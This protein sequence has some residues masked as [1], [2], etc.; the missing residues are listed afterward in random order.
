[1]EMVWLETCAAM[2]LQSP[3][4]SSLGL[5]VTAELLFPFAAHLGSA[6]LWGGTDALCRLN[7]LQKVQG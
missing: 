2:W 1:M 7:F 5:L 4:R 6:D 3:C